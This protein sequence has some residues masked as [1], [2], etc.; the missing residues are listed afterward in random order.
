[1]FVC[2]FCGVFA[3]CCK[4]NMHPASVYMHVFSAVELFFFAVVQLVRMFIFC[5]FTACAEDLALL[6]A[7]CTVLCVHGLA[8]PALMLSPRLAQVMF[9]DTGHV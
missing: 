6:Y 4:V 9:S 8:K 7:C 3:C 2:V 1:M 5:G